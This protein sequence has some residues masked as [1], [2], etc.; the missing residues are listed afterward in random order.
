MALVLT[1]DIGRTVAKVM[2]TAENYRNVEFNIAGDD[3]TYDQATAIFAKVTG[4][5]KLSAANK[6]LTSALVATMKALK[7]GTGATVDS[8]L[9]DWATYIHQSGYMKS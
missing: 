7:Q 9:M 3:L 8:D 2:L 5:K 4:R 6:Y 1:K